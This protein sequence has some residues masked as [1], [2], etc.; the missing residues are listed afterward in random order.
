MYLRN[1]SQSVRFYPVQYAMEGWQ[2]K[3]YELTMKDQANYTCELQNECGTIKWTY[4][5]EVI[6]KFV[7]FLVENFSFRINVCPNLRL[8]YCHRFPYLHWG[9]LI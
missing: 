7:I 4:N 9:I 5:L 6:R 2:L 1:S 3:I 8:S